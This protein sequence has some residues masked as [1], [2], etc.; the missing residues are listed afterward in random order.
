MEEMKIGKSY[1]RFNLKGE[2]ISFP[3]G[4]KTGIFLGVVPSGFFR[5]K[6]SESRECIIK[7]HVSNYEV[8]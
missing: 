5:F 2:K 3:F 6:L 4:E 1:A 7:P 8:V